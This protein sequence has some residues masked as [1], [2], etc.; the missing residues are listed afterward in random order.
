MLWCD[1]DHRQWRREL[2]D[3]PLSHLRGMVERDLFWQN[4]KKRRWAKRRL[5]WR[6]HRWVGVIVT[7]LGLLTA[8]AS[9]VAAYLNLYLTHA[10]P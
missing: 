9:M 6:E 3:V 10:R 4:P 1:R 2:R 7:V 8:G 5:W